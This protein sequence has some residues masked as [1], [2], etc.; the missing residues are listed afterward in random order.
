MR[1]AAGR[2]FTL[3][4]LLVSMALVSILLMLAAP[5][6]SSAFVR[7]RVE[8]TTNEL[9]ADLQYARSEAVRRRA[10]VV[11]ASNAG[12]NG[13]SIVSGATTIKTVALAPGLTVTPSVSLTFSAMRATASNAGNFN[14]ADAR[15]TITLRAATD[16]MGRVQMC[17]TNAAVKGYPSCT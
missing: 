4:E 5:S 3:V 13:Y 7:A 9:G 10:D 16:L 15:G 8:G 11:L 12:G 1:N 2:G 14:I 6:F 17:S